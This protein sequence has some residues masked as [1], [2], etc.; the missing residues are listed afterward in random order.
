[1]TK[2][3]RFHLIWLNITFSRVFLFSLLQSQM[4][5]AFTVFQVIKMICRICSLRSI[6]NMEKEHDICNYII[7]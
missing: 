2:L 7:L 5:Q 1:M 3:S 4:G 6:Q